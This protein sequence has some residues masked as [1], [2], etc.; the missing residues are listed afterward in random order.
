MARSHR[1]FMYRKAR[2]MTTSTDATA[3]N[4][5]AVVRAQIAP[6][7]KTQRR[8]LLV[9]ASLAVVVVGGL[10]SVWAY[11]AGSDAQ[12]VIA[13]RSTIERGQVIEASSALMPTTSAG[14]GS[15]FSPVS[16]G[17]PPASAVMTTRA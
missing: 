1:S 16:V 15:G 12:E 6:P 9:V 11:Q 4:A 17:T 7:P 8:P 5:P 14:T 3:S 10:G 2:R 13:V